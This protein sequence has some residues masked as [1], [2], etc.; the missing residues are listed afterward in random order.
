MNNSPLTCTWVTV[1]DTAGREHMEAV[2]TT[3]PEVAHA[4]HAA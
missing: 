1:V 2:W 4:S 3:R